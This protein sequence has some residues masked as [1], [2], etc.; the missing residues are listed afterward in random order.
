MYGSELNMCTTFERTSLHQCL[1]DAA[2]HRSRLSLVSSVRIPEICILAVAK[3]QNSPILAYINQAVVPTND[4][5]L[6]NG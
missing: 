2:R 5:G 4:S 3:I 6:V 1:S